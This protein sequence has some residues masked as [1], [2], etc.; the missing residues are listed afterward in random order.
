MTRDTLT[1]YLNRQYAALATAAGFTDYDLVDD[2][3]FRLFGVA[4]A[5][6]PTGTV[7]DSLT[8]DVFAVADYYI[9]RAIWRSL[10]MKVDLRDG[11]ESAKYSQLFAQTKELM[12]AALKQVPAKYPVEGGDFAFGRLQLDY[13]EPQTYGV[14]PFNPY[15]D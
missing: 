8:S 11:D 2:A 1:L 13:L 9:L 15:F 4:E 12:D 3:T 10:A 14:G 7:D 6:L 5:D